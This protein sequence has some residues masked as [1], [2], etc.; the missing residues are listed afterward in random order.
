MIILAI[1]LGLANYLTRDF[2][3]VLPDQRSR[4]VAPSSIASCVSGKGVNTQVQTMMGIN[5]FLIAYGYLVRI[6]KILSVASR[7][8]SG[9]SASINSRA[10]TIFF[11]CH[12]R[13]MAST[14][15]RILKPLWAAALHVLHLHLE[16]L[17]SYSAEVWTFP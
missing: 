1:F 5:M 16:L 11:G 9:A 8:A 15:S 3:W 6:V 10:R 2:E 14:V 17:T 4:G 13:S 7:S 12:T